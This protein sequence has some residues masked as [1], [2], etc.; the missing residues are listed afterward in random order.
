MIIV[1]SRKASQAVLRALLGWETINVPHC[2]IFLQQFGTIQKRNIKGN[3]PGISSLAE[4]VSVLSL[5][6]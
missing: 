1:E 6:L 4:R 5:S 2:V 3:D